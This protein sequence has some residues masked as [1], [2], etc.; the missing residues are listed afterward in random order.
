MDFTNFD[1]VW[2]DANIVPRYNR[3]GVKT[4]QLVVF[5]SCSI[6]KKK[7]RAVTGAPML[8]RFFGPSANA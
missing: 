6:A 2:R 1:P 7:K 3:A 5:P 8:F 4:D